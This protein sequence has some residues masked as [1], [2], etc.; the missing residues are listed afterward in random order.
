MSRVN[1]L[2]EILSDIYVQ[3]LMQSRDIHSIINYTRQIIEE[4]KYQEKYANLN[5]Y[6]NWCLHIKLTKSSKVYLILNEINKLIIP[7]LSNTTDLSLVINK[8][9]ES[10]SFNHLKNDFIELYT[11]V[12][13]PLFL[14]S[15]QSNW[16]T[17]I[18]LIIR[19]I[20]NKPIEVP[21]N[22]FEPVSSSRKV[23][24]PEKTYLGMYRKSN[25]YAYSSAKSPPEIKI[26]ITSIEIKQNNDIYDGAVYLEI[27][28]TPDSQVTILCPLH[29]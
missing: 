15:T 27:S 3:N 13:L 11:E 14:F 28:L 7:D 6:C 26:F 5:F 20:L 24:G 22:I 2:K 25:I 23:K 10:L 9:S 8:V 4:K 17:I 16:E 21:S 19:E 12:K 1:K 29:L 18:S